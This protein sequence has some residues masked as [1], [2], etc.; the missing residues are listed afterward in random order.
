MRTN[1]EKAL[2]YTTPPLDAKM[3]VTGHPVIHLWLTTDSVDLDVFV[4]LETVDGKGKSTYIT[5]GN[6]RASHRAISAAPYENLDLPYHSHYESDLEPVSV[7]EP[8]E[9]VFDLLPTSYQF[10]EGDRIRITLTFA[11]AGNFDTPVLDPP[12]TLKLHRNSSHP[13]YVDLPVIKKR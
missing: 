1:D 6:L 4:Y 2:T 3:E 12:P 5:E 8:F 10:N 11:D 9:L 13:S 7:G